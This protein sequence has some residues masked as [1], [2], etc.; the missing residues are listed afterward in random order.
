[1]ECAWHLLEARPALRFFPQ[2]SFSVTFCLLWRPSSFFL[3]LDKALWGVFGCDLVL[4]KWMLTD[5]LFDKF[6]QLQ[7]WSEQPRG[8]CGDDLKF[9]TKA[10]K[11]R[12]CGPKYGKIDLTGEAVLLLYLQF[13]IFFNSKLALYA[14]ISLN[15]L[16]RGPESEAV[17][18]QR[19]EIWELDKRCDVIGLDNKQRGSANPLWW[20]WAPFSSAAVGSLKTLLFAFSHMSLS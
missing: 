15:W 17:A 14:T 12:N 13:I 5:W 18:F 3:W 1:M 16:F 11:K 7:Q 2:E 8:L 6:C 19:W 10:L 9:K 20:E 4:S